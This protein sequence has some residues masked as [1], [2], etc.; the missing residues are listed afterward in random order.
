VLVGPQGFG[1]SQ[2][3]ERELAIIRQTHEPAFR[4]IPVILPKT[5]SDLPFDFLRNLTRVDWS[6][7]QQEIGPVKMRFVRLASPGPWRRRLRSLS[8]KG[9]RRGRPETV[10]TMRWTD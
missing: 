8:V 9:A 1:N 7:G 5:G 10:I 2:Q 4:V 6:E 3:Y